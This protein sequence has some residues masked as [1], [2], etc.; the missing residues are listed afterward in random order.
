MRAPV[1]IP[2]A[3]IDLTKIAELFRR[4]YLIL[5][6]Q[7][8]GSREQPQAF[9]DWLESYRGEVEEVIA[10]AASSPGC[11]EVEVPIAGG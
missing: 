6:Q 1:P 7:A 8:R 4:S 5:T 9:D 10:R 2:V 11:P 3:E